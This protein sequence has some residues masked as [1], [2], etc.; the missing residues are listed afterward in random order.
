M[1]AP[2]LPP[3]PERLPV[4]TTDAHTHLAS[5]ATK[6]GVGVADLLER[7]A[8]VGIDRVVDV[9]C[10]L[11]SSVGAVQEAQA[12]DAVIAAVA[13]HPHDAVELGDGLDEALRGVEALLGSTDRIR[14]VGETG[15]DYYWVTDEPGRAVQRDAFAA[16]IGWA[17][18]HDLALVVHD[19]DAH[20]DLL[21]VLDAEGWPTRVQFHCFSGDADLA[22]RCLDRGAYL[23]FPGTVTFKANEALR[24]AARITPADRLLAETDAPYLTPVPVRGRPNA[25]YLLPHTVRFLAALRGEPV[26][27]VCAALAAN[28]TALF[29]N[30]GSHG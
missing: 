18:E 20:H 2:A 5:T 7:A 13:I 19:R 28:A 4:A 12:H 27:E 25:S 3:A 10:D 6:T 9:G 14:A 17:R 26:E 29:G 16:H 21:D 8:A 23:S 30:W 15:L 24:E 22:R 1:I 11:P